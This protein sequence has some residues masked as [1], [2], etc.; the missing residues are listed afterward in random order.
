MTRRPASS[1]AAYLARHVAAR[2]GPP[3]LTLLAATCLTLLAVF[4]G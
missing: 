1:T 3:L 2:L 4:G